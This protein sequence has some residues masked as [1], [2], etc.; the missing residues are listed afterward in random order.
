M[1]INRWMDKEDVVYIHTMEY[2]SAIKKNKIMPFA[3]TW[4][5]L[6]IIILSEVNQ[7]NIMCYHFYVESK[8]WYKW[9]Y[10]QNRNR[11]TDIE[12][13]FMVTKGEINYSGGDKLEVWD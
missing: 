6:E 1:A 13:K 11:F 3:A 5:D 8:K 12:K 10:L 7:T 9:T 2:Y 4:M